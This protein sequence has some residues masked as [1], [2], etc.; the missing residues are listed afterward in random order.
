MTQMREKKKKRPKRN[1]LERIELVDRHKQQMQI[2]RERGGNEGNICSY[3]VQFHF[4][5]SNILI[6]Y[7]D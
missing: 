2:A 6:E 5:A 1:K 7:S 4:A 3:E